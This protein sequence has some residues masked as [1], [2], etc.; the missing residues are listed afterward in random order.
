MTIDEI[1]EFVDA[2]TYTHVRKNDTEFFKSM[3]TM[4]PED[5]RIQLSITGLGNIAFT[6]LHIPDKDMRDRAI[7]LF[8][9]LQPT[10]Q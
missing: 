1:S 3:L 2:V 8:T 6:A 10:T 9:R 7:A 5:Q 4:P